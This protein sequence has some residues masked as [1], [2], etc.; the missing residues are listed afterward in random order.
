MAINSPNV[1][2]LDAE[3]ASVTRV[4]SWVSVGDAEAVGGSYLQSNMKGDYLQFTFKGSALWVRFKFDSNCGKASVTVDNVAYPTLDL[5]SVLPMFKYVNVAV[6]LDENVSHTVKIGVAGEKNPDS[7]DY[8]VNVDAFTFRTTEEALSLQSIEYIDLINVINKINRIGEIQLLTNISNIDVVKEISL[9]KKIADA[10][11]IANIGVAM[12]GDFETGNLAGWTDPAG[13]ATVTDK[14]P[15]LIRGSKYS[16]NLKHSPYGIVQYFIPPKPLEDIVNF[17]M[18]Q[19][20]ENITTEW[21]N[22]TFFLTDGLHFD[23]SVPRNNESSWQYKD[24][25]SILQDRLQTIPDLRKKLFY[26]IMI[27]NAGSTDGLYIDSFNIVVMP[28]EL[29]RQSVNLQDVSVTVSPGGEGYTPNAG[30]VEVVPGQILCLSLEYAS[31]VTLYQPVT[32]QILVTLRNYDGTVNET[33]TFQPVERPPYATQGYMKYNCFLVIPSGVAFAGVHAYFKH[34]ESTPVT[35]Y[36]RNIKF[37]PVLRESYKWR[38]AEVMD[39][40]LAG[41]GSL[42]INVPIPESFSGVAV[43][44]KAVYNASATAGVQLEVYHS[45]DGVNWDSDTDDIVVHPFAAGATKQKT[46]IF[47]SICPYIRFRVKNLD[48]GYAATVSL[49]RTFI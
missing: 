13:V 42:D 38:R 36:L 29:K 8:Y 35:L 32:F 37:Y 19:Y 16:C 46:Y 14:H 43:T 25:L 3:D 5:Y 10:P 20:A 9:I 28:S 44:L 48:A 27:N 45:Q 30:L 18:Y 41:G 33:L 49:W 12:N 17:S 39:Y 22:I 1:L 26:A 6:G 11:W 24:L 47:P 2:I 21:A 7:T 23:F 40:S 15:D 31:S 34:G 4:G